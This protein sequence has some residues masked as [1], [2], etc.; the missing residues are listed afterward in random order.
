MIRRFGVK[1]SDMRTN[2]K[3][4]EN[5]FGRASVHMQICMYTALLINSDRQAERLLITTT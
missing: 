5:D 3:E 4:L 1:N 2:V